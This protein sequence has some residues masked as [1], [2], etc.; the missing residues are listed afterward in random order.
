MLHDHT[1]LKHGSNLH[2]QD[3]ALFN[4]AMSYALGKVGKPGMTLKDK[5]CQQYRMAR[6]CLYAFIWPS[7]IFY[8][9]L[10][11]CIVHCVHFRKAKA[12]Y[13]HPQTLKPMAPH[14]AI[15]P[16]NSSVLFQLDELYGECN[17]TLVHVED[18]R[19]S[20]PLSAWE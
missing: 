2:L 18:I 15:L 11:V 17:G 6:M 9:G 19:C 13:R 20:S 1:L 4:Q 16:D 8:G 12:A 7:R 10:T 14:D 5:N 3:A